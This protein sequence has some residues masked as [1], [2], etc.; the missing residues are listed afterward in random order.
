MLNLENSLS[1][2]RIL[3]VDD[4]VQARSSLKNMMGIIGAQRIDTATDGREAMELILENDYD[5]VLS[6]YNL[7]KGKDGQ[8]ILEEA[9][10]SNR[11]KA[12]AQFILVT[13][14]NAVERVMGALEYE[15]DAYITKPFTLSMLRER[16]KRIFHTK[17]E[18]RPINEAIDNGDINQAIEIANFLLESKPRLLLPVSR[19]LGKLYMRE[20]RYEEAL[21]VYSQPLN[22]R[23]VSWARLGQAICM[24]YLG[25]SLGALALI[26]QTLV[27]Y[28]MYV[29]CHDWAAR[30]LLALGKPEEAQEQL[31]L[32][33]AISPRAVLRQMELGYLASQNGDHKIAEAA[34]EQSIRLGRHSCYKT[35][36]N[37]LQFAREL[38]H[39]LS[40]EKTRDNINLRNKA[41]R[42]IDELRQEY[43]GH[44][45]IMFDTSIVESKTYV[46][47]AE[48]DKAKGAA[49]R[50]E[51]LLARIQAPTPD[52]QLQMTEAFIDVGEHI[53]AKDLINTMR[54]S[55]ASNLAQNALDKLRALEDK[56]NAMTIREHTAKLN[57]EGVSLYEQG[58]LMEA[59]E[60][61][62]Q[63]VKYDEVGVSVLLNAIQ[64]KVSHIE[65]TELDVRQ[66]KDCYILFK[67][68]GS[69]G[70]LDERYDRY[71][72]LKTTCIRLKRAAGV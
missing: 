31:E 4:L 42:A 60:V 22:T 16:L 62:D 23:M 70:H 9:R 44:V 34:F 25:D 3:I 43:S 49:D 5:L 50:A 51:S 6:D 29:Q 21:H 10:F 72:R 38:Q 59:I 11:L 48:S 8:Q 68:I 7:G 17:E 64:A 40:A 66:L 61:F 27:D 12:T 58:K 20:E 57:A 28:P 18:L 33:T 30:I 63:A 26:R 55:Q 14:E 13:G 54:D 65:R 53:K 39:G 47:V 19:I 52:Q 2:K 15:P 67:R 36:G 1:T 24:H 69:I 71:D 56:L 46:A 37:Y 45:S 41:L 35:S 32:A